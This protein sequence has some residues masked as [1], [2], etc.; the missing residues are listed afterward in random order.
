MREP[1]CNAENI[2]RTFASEYRMALGSLFPE[3]SAAALDAAAADFEFQ[4]REEF[5]VLSIHAD[6]AGDRVH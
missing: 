5:K 4:M 2:L 1:D 3:K 6:K